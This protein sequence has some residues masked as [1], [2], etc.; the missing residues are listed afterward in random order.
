M[1]A[2]SLSFARPDDI[3]GEPRGQHDMTL[4]VLTH[5]AGQKMGCNDWLRLKAPVLNLPPPHP[6]SCPPTLSTGL[7]FTDHNDLPRAQ[8]DSCNHSLPPKN[9]QPSDF[10][11]EHNANGETLSFWGASYTYKSQHHI[12][13]LYQI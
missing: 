13:N 12:M 9:V 8:N 7:S 1:P 6:F 10:T 3:A 5:G 4:R 11:A 2:P